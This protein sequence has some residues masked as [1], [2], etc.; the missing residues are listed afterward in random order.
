[1]HRLYAKQ[2]RLP[3]HVINNNNKYKENIDAHDLEPKIPKALVQNA[4]PNISHTVAG[5][6]SPALAT[7]IIY[8]LT[9]VDESNFSQG[10]NKGLTM[11]TRE[12]K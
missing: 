3:E 10:I 11:Q 6:G 1:M 8:S 7:N 5:Q 12:R 2:H 9:Q 4:N